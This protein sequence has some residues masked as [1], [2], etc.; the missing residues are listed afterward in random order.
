MTTIN[1]KTDIKEAI[2]ALDV[3][4]K[5]QI[6]YA[7]TLMLNALAT[8]T[9]KRVE[10]DIKR[11]LDR[12]TNYAQRMMG[13]KYANKGNLTSQVNVR[14]SVS[15]GETKVLGHLFAGRGRSGKGVEGA[16]VDKGIMPRGMWAMPGD[17]APLDLFGN[18]KRSFIKQLI[19]YL[20]ANKVVKKSAQFENRQRKQVKGATSS[21]YFVVNQK[22]QGGLPLGIWQHVGFG[23]GKALRPVIIFVSREPV[24]DRYFNLGNTAQQVIARDARFE[25]DKAM[26]YAIATAK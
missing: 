12:P 17:G 16:L 25:F 26:A 7:T 18:I 21:Q 15:G 2:R 13:I 5:R 20:A 6:P 10:V 1:I 3:V 24:Y 4:S 9:K 14:G 11:N 8:S 19:G 22:K 23:S